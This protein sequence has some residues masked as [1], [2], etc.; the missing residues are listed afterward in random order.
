M[1]ISATVDQDTVSPNSLTDEYDTPQSSLARL[2]SEVEDAHA[3]ALGI[4]LQ[5]LDGSKRVQCVADE[6]L[7]LLQVAHPVTTRDVPVGLD[8]FAGSARSAARLLA[9]TGTGVIIGTHLMECRA[10]RRIITERPCLSTPCT[11]TFSAASS[12]WISSCS[13]ATRP[14]VTG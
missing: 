5:V 11:N 13:T 14:L 4:A 1:L 9:C 8:S 2:T 12:A 10:V 6:L 7:C 3:F